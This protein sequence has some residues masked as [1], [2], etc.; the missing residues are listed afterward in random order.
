MIAVVLA[1][2]GIAAAGCEGTAGQ[3]GDITQTGAMLHAQTACRADTTTNPCTGWF[4]YW[5]AGDTGTSM[6]ART[7]PVTVNV[8]TNGFIDFQQA[9]SGLTPDTLYR[10]QFCGYGDSNVAQPG[11][12]VGQGG[13]AISAPGSQPDAGDFSATQSFRTAGPGT[14][15]TT[16]LGRPLSTADAST[17]PISRDAGLSA[18]YSASESL[19][20]FGDTSQRNGPPFLGGTT[21]AA[22]PYA[23]GQAPTQLRELPP[24]PAPPEPGRTSPALFLPVPQGLLTPDNPPVACGTNRSCPAA[25][26]SGLARIPGTSRMLISYAEV[27]VA[28]D[29]TWPAERIKLAEYDPATNRILSTGTPF[30]ANPLP[31]GVPFTQNLGSPVFGTDG[32][33]YF[34]GAQRETGTVSVARVPASP[35]AWGNGANYQWWGRPGGGPPQ[36]TGDQSAVTSIISG[37]EPWGVHVADFTGVGSHALAMIVKSAF[38]TSDFRIYT[39]TS[40]AGTWTAGPA[41]RIPDTCQGGGFGCYAYAGHTELSTPDRF[42]FSWLSPGDRGGFGHIR[43][44][45]IAW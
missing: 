15:G 10:T 6:V 11:V 33:V 1:T 7:S 2:V 21:A 31:A 9:I 27:C 24:P 28:V 18:P 25:W 5:A 16:D 30:V 37:V 36:W 32:F 8:N 17:N 41:G 29:R 12:C 19:W 23:R 42:V 3:P 45:T 40:P 43:L 14:A 20:L 44:G 34:Y 22:G 26:P 38:F 13:G 4:Q 35:A 39:A